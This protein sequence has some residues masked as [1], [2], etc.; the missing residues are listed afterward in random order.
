MAFAGLTILAIQ[1]F[2]QMSA[3]LGKHLW[4]VIC[5]ACPIASLPQVEPLLESTT[6]FEMRSALI[7]LMAFTPA[8]LSALAW[9]RK[10]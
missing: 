1:F 2:T 9:S 4:I 6:G 10:D 5:K 3:Q 8:R 7:A